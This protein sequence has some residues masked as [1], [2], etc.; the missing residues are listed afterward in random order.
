MIDSRTPSALSVS[1][2]EPAVSVCIAVRNC[3]TYIAAAIES[4]L[5]QRYDDFEVVVVDNA[6]TDRTVGTVQ[7]IRDDR[8]RLVENP[9][10]VGLC[11]NWNRSIEE[12]RGRYVKVL[13]ADD[14]L[15][16]DCLAEQAAVFD[17]DR[18][19]SVA[20]VCCPRDIID[21]HGRVRMRS[22]GWSTGGR[23][24]RMTGRE[25][26][27]QMARAGR[28]LIGEPLTTMFRR[29]DALGI[30]GFDPA[31]Y[32]SLPVCIDWDLWCR[33]LEKGDLVVNGRALGAIRV[34]AGS[35]SLTLVGKFAENDRRFIASLSDKGLAN[36]G[37]VD[38]ALGSARAWRDAWLRRVFYAYLKVRGSA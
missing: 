17:A 9:V 10:N 38:I 8:V 14:I 13:C 20:L 7:A 21:S 19:R 36:I 32:A 30:G 24:R 18:D 27:K 6:S 22:R 2:R 28:N 25:A 31:L 35:A 5:G 11:H 34:N 33:L 15:Y 29:E 37:A 16:P 12:A 3:E 1:K 23:P 4:V 26:M